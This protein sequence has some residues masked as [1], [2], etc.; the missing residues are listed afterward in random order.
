[1][2]EVHHQAESDYKARDC[3][4]ETVKIGAGSALAGVVYSTVSNAY[5]THQ[6]DRASVF[7]RTGTSVK[8]FGI[9]GVTYSATYCMMNNLRHKQDH[10]NSGAA[11]A[12]AGATLGLL[13]RSFPIMFGAAA[14][15]G[16]TM[17]VFDYTGSS[18]R[19]P[20]GDA[21]YEER[22]KIR[23]SHLAN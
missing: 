3:V 7:T 13:S 18:V 15:I 22:E 20:F 9:V 6:F 8:Y 2:S 21:T 12:A 23:R 16:A 5:Q 17:W 4:G 14:A 1:M 10:W 11:G 19:G